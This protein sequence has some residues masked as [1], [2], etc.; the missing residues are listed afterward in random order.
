MYKVMAPL[1]ARNVY[2]I[3]SVQVKVN[4]AGMFT[5]SLDGQAPKP[6]VIL[7]YKKRFGHSITDN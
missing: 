5:F 6:I 3:D 4:I 2:E 1:G 7:S